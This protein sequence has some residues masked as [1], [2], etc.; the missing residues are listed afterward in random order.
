MVGPSLS[1]SQR[2][3]VGA[4]AGDLLGV[5]K[6]DAQRAWHGAEQRGQLD[7]AIRQ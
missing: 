2:G 5:A 1:V 3:G 7:Q 4:G 6:A